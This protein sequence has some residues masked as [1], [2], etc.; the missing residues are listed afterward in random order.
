VHIAEDLAAVSG[1]VPAVVRQLTGLLVER[2][3]DVAVQVAHA[4]GERDGFP[5]PVDVFSFPPSGLG[6]FWK[7]CDSLPVGML[8][9][10]K[11]SEAVGSAVFHV[12]GVW[13]APQYFAAK[14]AHKAGAPFVVSA[15]GM[16]E[17]WLWSEQGLSILLKKRLY[18]AAM[19]YPALRHA[20]VVHAITPLEK[21][22][23]QA[24]FPSSRIEVIPN[25]INVS[26]IP[27]CNSGKLGKRIL[28]LG[29]LEPKKGLALLLL[30]FARA[31][32]GK[33]WVLDVVGPM[34][35]QAYFDELKSIVAEYG[36][37]DRVHFHGALFGDEKIKLIESAWVMVVPSYSEV[38]G[39]VN[40]EAAASCLP[41]ITTYQTG[42]DDW[43]DGGGLLVQPDRADLAHSLE[44]ACSWSERERTERGQS[45]WQLVRERY[46]WQS[47]LPQWYEL[48]N[49]L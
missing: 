27:P 19:A 31:K 39:L 38:V 21:I 41:T 3:A 47:V 23:L 13:S 17:P 46:S 30:A 25:A 5:S 35:S 32:I 20:A 22:H 28:F 24:L 45:S 6:G 26:D 48:Y 15:H 29:R 34:W 33:E 18:W 16:L 40:L 43:E 42:L 8:D 7:W 1:G 49:S 2:Y 14:A 37:G 4:T 10:A 36:L 12:H 11:G 9:L 44:L